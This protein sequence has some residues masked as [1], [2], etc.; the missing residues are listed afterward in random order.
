[1]LGWK[2]C[3]SQD[4]GRYVL[5][6]V[7]NTQNRAGQTAGA[8]R[9]SMNKRMAFLLPP[10]HTEVALEKNLGRKSRE[11]DSSFT[12]NYFRG[13]ILDSLCSAQ[14]LLPSGCFQRCRQV[15]RNSRDQKIWLGQRDPSHRRP[16]VT[17]QENQTSIADLIILSWTNTVVRHN[18]QY[19][20]KRG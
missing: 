1:M 5:Y 18:A 3:E 7:C 2:L 11:L 4:F 9:K 15:S 20:S 6:P 14:F 13:C 19:C 8:Q 12:S 10:P 17:G 16:G